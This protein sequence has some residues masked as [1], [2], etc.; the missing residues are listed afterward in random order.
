MQKYVCNLAL[1]KNILPKKQQLEWCFMKTIPLNRVNDTCDHHSIQSH[2][3]DK[4]V[5]INNQTGMKA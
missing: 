4:D 2:D 3:L 1:E 5:F